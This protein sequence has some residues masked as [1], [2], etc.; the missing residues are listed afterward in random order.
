M[1]LSH[2]IHFFFF[3]EQPFLTHSCFLLFSC[4]LIL[5]VDCDTSKTMGGGD[6]CPDVS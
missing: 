5:I 3:F 2:S 1:F 4:F 6:V